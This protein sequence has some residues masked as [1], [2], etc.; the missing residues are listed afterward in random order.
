MTSSLLLREKCQLQ[1]I[2]VSLRDF[3]GEK[4]QM[5]PDAERRSEERNSLKLSLQIRTEDGQEFSVLSQDVSISGFRLAASSSLLGKKIFLYLP[6]PND[7][8][9]PEVL[10]ARIL[11]CVEVANG[12]FENGGVFLGLD[13]P[14]AD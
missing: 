6:N 7:P 4:G 14:R 2:R 1:K 12:V 8:T 10:T 13:S 3:L 11:W 9:A 5:P